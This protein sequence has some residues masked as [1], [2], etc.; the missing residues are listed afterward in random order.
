[1]T[2]WPKGI[3]NAD[4]SFVLANE[5]LYN[6]LDAAMRSACANLDMYL[7]EPSGAAWPVPIMEM[8]ER[9]DSAAASAPPMAVV[10]IETAA[11]ATLVA[12]ASLAALL[13]A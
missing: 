12:A 3:Q 7:P 13:W 9:A 2:D 11:A 8:L 1:M 5:A 10:N 6:S 4:A